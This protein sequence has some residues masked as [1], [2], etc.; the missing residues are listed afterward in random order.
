MSNVASPGRLMS[1]M[2]SSVPGCLGPADRNKHDRCDQ[3]NIWHD[4]AFSGG[5]LGRPGGRTQCT[6]CV[7]CIA[8]QP[9]DHPPSSGLDYAHWCKRHLAR[10]LGWKQANSSTV[11]H[12][13]SFPAHFART[14]RAHSESCAN[15]A[16]SYSCNAA[17]VKEYKQ[18]DLPAL[19]QDSWPM[20]ACLQVC[21]STSAYTV[22][23]VCAVWIMSKLCTS[24]KLQ[25]GMRQVPQAACPASFAAGFT[26]ND[27]LFASF[28]PHQCVHCVQCVRSVNHG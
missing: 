10:T 27:C 23:A 16:W 1:F 12:E 21:C 3:H 4:C 11:Q 28:L 25:C 15:H 6:R 9:M 17:C 18:L 5:R 20:A 19:Q 22:R 26:A 13:S 7:R 14:V 2:L 8:L 24:L